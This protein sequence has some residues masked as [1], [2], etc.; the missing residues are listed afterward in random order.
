[1]AYLTKQEI[2]DKY[3]VVINGFTFSANRISGYTTDNSLVFAT[4]PERGLDF[5]IPDI[6]DIPKG[7]VSK[8]KLDF[9]VLYQDEW[10]QF[11]A[12]TQTSEFVCLYYD[13]QYGIKWEKKVYKYPSEF[14]NWQGLNTD[15]PYA[16]NVS[17]TFIATN[18]EISTISIEYN[19]NG[20]NGL[21]N[22]ISGYFGQTIQLAE[23][24]YNRLGYALIGWNEKQDGSGNFY[25]L[26]SY[27]ALSTSKLLYAVWQLSNIRILSFDYA[28]I[29]QQERD[30]NNDEWIKSK[31]VKYTIPTSTIVGTLPNPTFYLTKNDLLI[32]VGENNGWWNIPFDWKINGDRYN[33]WLSEQ[34]GNIEQYTSDTLYL[35]NG[36]TTIYRHWLP[37]KYTLFFNSNSE[38]DVI[39][40]ATPYNNAI[41]YDGKNQLPLPI[42]NGHTFA[43]WFTDDKFTKSF[44]SK[45]QPA[46]NLVLHAKWEKIFNGK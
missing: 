21:V 33:E 25:A 10:Q 13:M 46:E 42:K 41:I 26:G 34:I 44:T 39:P 1:M 15:R 35:V 5:S 32:K 29:N 43:G 40:I 12:S 16:I 7:E 36:N 28:N 30:I 23:S 22:G 4:D 27:I 37:Y 20:G 3:S 6:N 38:I 18:N 24:G 8:L 11:L 2:I 19:A 9:K 31:E 14:L 17:F 45:I